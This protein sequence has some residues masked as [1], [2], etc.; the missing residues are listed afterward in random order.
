MSSLDDLRCVDPQLGELLPFHAAGSLGHAD[1][2]LFA[3]HLQACARCA[4]EEHLMRELAR[5]I[6]SLRA[7][8]DPAAALPAAP[9]PRG[10]RLLL[11][12]ALAAVAAL[13]VLAVVAWTG[14]P[15][16]T[17][18]TADVRVLESRIAQLEEHETVLAQAVADAHRTLGVSPL[19]GV[20]IASP[21]NF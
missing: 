17:R 7:R 9:H 19:V 20:P 21:P 6:A 18:L 14:A 10:R 3:A 12:G 2:T 4:Q 16:A 5:G 11:G 15:S 8:P 1:R 13:L